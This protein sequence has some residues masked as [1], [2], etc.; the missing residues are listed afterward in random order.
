MTHAP[1]SKH[2]TI[3]SNR[4]HVG[5]REGI[6]TLGRVMLTL[7][8][9]AAIGATGCA[10]KMEAPPASALKQARQDSKLD[11]EQLELERRHVA[12]PPAYGNKVVLAKNQ[13]ESRA[14]F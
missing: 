1:Q 13:D 8:M 14:A 9:V 4:E 12:P 11:R 3:P 7:A 10:S 6:R 5:K 2:G